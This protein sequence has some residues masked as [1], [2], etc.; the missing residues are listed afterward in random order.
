MNYSVLM[1]V[2]YKENPGYLDL[3]IKSMLK[4]TIKTNDFVLIEDG[5]LTIELENVINKYQKKHKDIFNIIKLET[6]QGLGKA[7]AI[8]IN[9]CK[10]ELIA[11]MD[12]D[13]YSIPTRIEEQLNIL[14]QDSK[15]DIIGSW[16][17][18]FKENPNNVILTKHLPEKNEDIIK[19]SKRRNPFSHPSV[20]FK[21]SSVLKANNY[22]EYH[23]VEDYDLWI[24]MIQTGSKCYNVQ[25]SLICV[26]V[27]D[28]LYKR[29]GGIKYLKSILKFKKE[30]YKKGYFSLKDYFISSSS[31]II[32]CL[33]PS[34]IRKMIYTKLLRK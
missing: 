26:R 27:N 11:R 17:D 31:S 18:E 5:P 19:Y 14:N 16:H 24:R 22:R 10:N 28:D 29:R 6:N 20:I 25:K 9:A 30:Q 23:L 1:S 33:L 13:D 7:L 15:L 8:G 2:Y 32:V 34:S 4:Q 21:K 3:S 12:S